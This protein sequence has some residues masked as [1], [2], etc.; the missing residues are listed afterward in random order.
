MRSAT[1]YLIAIRQAEHALKAGNC[2][3]TFSIAGPARRRGRVGN[4]AQPRPAAP[5]LLHRSWVPGVQSGLAGVRA[6]PAFGRGA[7]GVSRERLAADTRRGRK[8]PRVIEAGFS[9]SLGPTRPDCPAVRRSLV[10]SRA[11]PRHPQE[12]RHRPAIPQRRRGHRDQFCRLSKVLS[13]GGEK[14]LV[15]STARASQP[16]PVEAQYAL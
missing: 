2:A 16:E 1:E 3:P 14:E 12:E 6:P 5:Y 8:S 15:V 13:G 10:H 4:A 11:P 9:D 7:G